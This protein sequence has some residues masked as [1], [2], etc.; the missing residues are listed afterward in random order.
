MSKPQKPANIKQKKYLLEVYRYT[1]F[2]ASRESHG[3]AKLGQHLAGYLLFYSR[4]LCD[5]TYNFFAKW[6]YK[7]Q[8]SLLCCLRFNR[9]EDFNVVAIPGTRDRY[10][11]T[12]F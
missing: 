12:H 2:K 6:I 3:T 5:T 10:S 7:Y 11:C 4:G 8:D 1:L 9:L